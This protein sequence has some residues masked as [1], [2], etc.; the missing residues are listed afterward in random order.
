M[1]KDFSVAVHGSFLH[2]CSISSNKF[3]EFVVIL[4]LAAF[5][6]LTSVGRENPAKSYLSLVP[7]NITCN[8][9]ISVRLIIL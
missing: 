9:A 7:S 4:S 1:M 8:L 5:S 3:S 2:A 6:P